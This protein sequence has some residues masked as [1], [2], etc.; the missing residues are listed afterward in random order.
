MSQRI[1]EK[2]L[3]I[4]IIAPFTRILQKVKIPGIATLSLYDILEMYILGIVKG[5]LSSRAGGIAYS[6][7]MA[8]FPFLIFILTLIPLVPIEGF[9][10]DFLYLLGQWMPASTSDEVFNQV[11]DYIMNHDYGGVLSSYFVLSILLMTNGINA[12]FG[13]FEYSY[14]VEIER[15]VIKQYLVALGV[16]ILLGFYLL[17][18]VAVAFYFEVGIEKLNDAGLLDNGVS[19]IVL[20]QKVFFV[21]MVFIS[22]STLFYF[23]TKEGKHHSFVS[24]G[25]ILTTLLIILLIY[26]FGIYVVRY[27]RYNEL[28]GSIGTLLLFMLFTWLNAIILLLGFELNASLHRV[29]KHLKG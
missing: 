23:G 25:S 8:I 29:K 13:G 27:S 3:K 24:P 16:S 2:L 7:L 14:H 28:Y 20:G 10:E 6:F 19:W 11:I 21:A 26:L 12:V 18:T 1:E 17:L 15:S 22:I 5:A 4:P 9:Q